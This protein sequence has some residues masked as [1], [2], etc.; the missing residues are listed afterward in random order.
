MRYGDEARALRH[1]HAGLV[2]QADRVAPDGLGSQ[3]TALFRTITVGT[4]PTSAQRCYAAVRVAIEVDET[5]GATPTLTDGDRT[6][7]ANV[8]GSIPPSGTHVLATLID[9]RWIM[10]YG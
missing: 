5:E 7:I 4:Y 6:Y 10:Q 8:G 9:G 2:D 3:P 1:R